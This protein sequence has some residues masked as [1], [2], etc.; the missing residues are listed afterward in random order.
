MP[1]NKPWTPYRPGDERALP[2]NLGVYEIGDDA[3]NVLYV[4]YAGGRTRFGLRETIPAC[5]DAMNP[6]PV[7]RARARAYRYEVNQMYMTRWID[8]L[9]RH[10]DAHGRPPE[11]NEAS[12]EPLPRLGRL[13]R[14]PGDGGRGS[15]M[16]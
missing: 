5:F 13:I 11:G 7:L 3:G 9:T 16:P 1:L 14:G 4:G 15:A 2:G 12:S 8:L 10:R 6:N